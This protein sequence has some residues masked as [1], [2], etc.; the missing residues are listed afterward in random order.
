MLMTSIFR[1][2]ESLQFLSNEEYR[3][4]TRVCGEIMITVIKHKINAH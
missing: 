1:N 2:V 3:L 4:D